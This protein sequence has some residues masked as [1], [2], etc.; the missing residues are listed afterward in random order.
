MPQAIDATKGE[1]NRNPPGSW[2]TKSYT[3]HCATMVMTRREEQ[4]D[5]LSRV[6]ANGS[7]RGLSAVVASFVVTPRSL[8]KR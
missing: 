4:V 1:I 7:Q 5:L 2:S 6:F 8:M 3:N